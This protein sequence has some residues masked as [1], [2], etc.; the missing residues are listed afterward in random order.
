MTVLQADALLDTSRYR[1]DPALLSSLCNEVEKAFETHSEPGG[2]SLLAALRV[3]GDEAL[4]SWFAV[5]ELAVASLG[6]A[7]LQ[8][9]RLAAGDGRETLAIPVNARRASL[10]F[11]TTLHPQGWQMPTL[12]D[13]IAGDYRT[14]DGWIR[15][16][17]NAPHH[18]AAALAVLGTAGERAQ[19]QKA[20]G[21]WKAQELESAVVA[22]GG[23]AA[24]MRSLENWA[25]HPQGHAVAEEP[26]M[27]WKQEGAVAADPTPVAAA[28]PLTGI[29]ILDL[30]RILAGPIASRFLAS[31]GAD[32]L[33]VDPP[34]W[35]EPGVIPEVT[36]GKR[37]AGLDLRQPDDRQ[38]FETLLADADVLLHGYRP[39]ALEAL[40]YGSAARRKMNPGLID[41]SLCAYGWSGPWAGRRGYDSL[42]QMSAGI[43]DYG[44]RQ[45][46]SDRPF[47]LPIQALDH[48]TGY[49]LAAAVLHALDQRRRTGAVLSARSSLAR[50]AHLLS[51][52]R[53][54]EKSGCIAGAVE[55]DLDNAIEATAWGSARRVR[56]PLTIDGIQPQWRNPAGRLHTAAPKWLPSA[57]ASAS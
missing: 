20:V 7:G 8:L 29:R 5:T 17:T 54:T 57:L 36:L 26:L 34:G 16:H 37:C 51:T 41:V 39:G 13:A 2:S 46:G 31:F 10:W 27:H 3:E 35:D 12:W 1:G 43:A 56:F 33:R 38:V 47:P 19:V 21:Q 23:C 11:G 15:L 42:V 25:L 32:V 24:E 18:R 44:R 4:P 48:A 22:A 45:E 9:A 49:L 14:A 50:V 6:M 28:A 40:G 55:A 52:T 30:T 53:K